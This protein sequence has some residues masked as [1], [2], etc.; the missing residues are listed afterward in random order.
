MAG[1]KADAEAFVERWAGHGDEI[2][3]G[4]TYWI[5]LFQNVLGVDDALSRLKFEVPVHTDP[6][7]STRATSTFSSHQPK[8]SWR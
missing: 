3:D 4:R 6:A 5:D 7:P 2:Q 8:R 1:T